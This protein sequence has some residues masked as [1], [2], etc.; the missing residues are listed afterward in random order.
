MKIYNSIIIAISILI[1]FVA[2][3]FFVFFWIVEGL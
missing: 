3:S 2:I 1:H